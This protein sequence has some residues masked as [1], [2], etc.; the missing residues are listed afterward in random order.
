AFKLPSAPGESVLGAE[1]GLVQGWNNMQ[2]R[3]S[4]LDIIANLR[5]RSADMKTWIDWENIV[6][7][8]AN[9]SF[10]ECG[11]GSPY[12]AIADSSG[13]ARRYASYLTYSRVLDADN[14]IALELTTGEQ[15]NAA[16]NGGAD[17]QWYGAN[18]NWYHR[19]SE[20][21]VWNSRIEWFNSE[22]PANVVMTGAAAGKAPFQWSS[23]KFTALTTN[24]TWN[25]MPAL[26]IR[27][28]LRYD[29]QDSDG[30]DAFAGGS[31]DSQLIASVDATFYF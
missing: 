26:R 27:P 6:G 11:C 28:E 3:N 16:L 15:E 12:P 1:V 19:L 8:G 24:V 17:A 4:D 20:T 5:W 25:P 18:L 14:R 10:A 7:N 2:D 13:D 23:G 9:D 29:I 21:L 22:D 31:K 30:P